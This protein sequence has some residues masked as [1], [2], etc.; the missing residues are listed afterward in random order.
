MPR[1][2][3]IIDAPKGHRAAKPLALS[4]EAQQVVDDIDRQWDLHPAAKALLR[5]IGEA[6]TSASEAEAVARET[7][8]VLSDGRGGLRS[9]P[10]SLL[11][12][13]YRAQAQAGLAKL[14]AILG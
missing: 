14:L 6:L 1:P 10:A 4:P 9:N 7:G 8:L 5:L 12:R 13:D 11:A 2:R 3:K